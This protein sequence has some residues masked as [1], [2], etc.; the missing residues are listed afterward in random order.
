VV[1]YVSQ[2]INK[3]KT[4]YNSYE[5]ECLIVVRAI[6]S[7]QCYFYGSPFTLVI[8]HQPFKFLMKLDR[9]IK[10]LAKWALILHEYN[11]DIVHNASRVN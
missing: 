11:F 8:N 4:K 10:K 6:L 7:F 1:A 3:T 5:G 2:S 9:F